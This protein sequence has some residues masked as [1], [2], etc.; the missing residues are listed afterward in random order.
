MVAPE[1]GPRVAVTCVVE[2]AAA[3]RLHNPALPAEANRRLYGKCN[4]EHG[5]GHT[6]RLEATVTGPVDPATGRVEAA[7]RLER[8]LAEVV[9]ARFDGVHLNH[10]VP[11]LAG[12]SPTSEHL[13]L[14]LYRLLAAAVG[15]ALARVVLWET[16]NNRFEVPG[17]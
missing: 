8:A 15:P 14:L 9:L 17:G 1:R 6:Y 10:D 4:N 3:H 16:P 7:A 11:E 13:A 2:F 12:T 5:H